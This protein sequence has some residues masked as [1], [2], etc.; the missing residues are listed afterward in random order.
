MLLRQTFKV[1]LRHGFQLLK[2]NN[3]RRLLLAYRL[4]SVMETVIVVF[5][6][7]LLLLLY[8][9]FKNELS[10]YSDSEE[11]NSDLNAQGNK[12]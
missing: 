8:L 10:G 12:V 9:L 7:F 5:L 11:E 1:T 4:V 6:N 3:T 2:I